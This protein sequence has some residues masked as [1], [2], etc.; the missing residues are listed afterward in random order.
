MIQEKVYVI[1]ANNDE[2]FSP[3]PSFI[4]WTDSVAKAYMFRSSTRARMVQK[5]VRAISGKKCEVKELMIEDQFHGTV[6]V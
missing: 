4:S 3:F 5:A 2:F 1:Q 6:D